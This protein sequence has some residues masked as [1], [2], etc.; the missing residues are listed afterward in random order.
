MTY[1]RVMAL[2][3]SSRCKVVHLLPHLLCG[4]DRDAVSG[5]LAP[6][7]LTYRVRATDREYSEVTLPAKIGQ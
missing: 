1:G 2:D 7:L 5:C 3:G 6:L 4:R